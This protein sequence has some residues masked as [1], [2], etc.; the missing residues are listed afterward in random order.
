MQNCSTAVHGYGNGY[1][2]TALN[3]LSSS[4]LETSEADCANTKRH[5]RSS[6]QFDN[7]VYEQPKLVVSIESASSQASGGRVDNPV[8]DQPKL[9]V[10]IESASSQASG[11]RVDNHVYDQP[12]LLLSIESASSQASGESEIVYSKLESSLQSNISRESNSQMLTASQTSSKLGNSSASSS[13]MQ[14]Q[15]RENA[16]HICQNASQRHLNTR[17][18]TGNACICDQVDEDMSDLTIDRQEMVTIVNASYEALPCHTEIMEAR[19][20]DSLQYGT[21]QILDSDH[22][23]L[24]AVVF[25]EVVNKRIPG[26]RPTF[27]SVEEGCGV[28]QTINPSCLKMGEK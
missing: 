7:P 3:T 19:A 2:V 18:T 21:T 28:D 10:S 6:E 1:H 16:T 23:P 22:M 5:R 4:E 13:C 20:L 27:S 9:V 12:K 25:S 26:Y 24:H 11:G 14:G 8:Y 15:L 17:D